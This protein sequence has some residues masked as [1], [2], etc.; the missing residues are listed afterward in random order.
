MILSKVINN[1][2]YEKITGITNRSI[3]GI[4]YDSRKVKENFLFVCIPGFS[5]DGHKFVNDAVRRGAVAVI[6][7]EKISPMPEVTIIYVRSSRESLANISNEFYDCPSEKLKL[8]GIT[9]TNGKTT[10]TYLIRSILQE[11]GEK[12][13]LIGTITY[14]LAGELFSSRNT[15]PESLDLQE[16]LNKMV[17]KKMDSCVMEVSSHSLALHRV[18]HCEFDV[19]VWTNLTLDH[20]D[21]HKTFNNYLNDK[22]KLFSALDKSSTKHIKKCA[23][24]NIDDEYS[25]YFIEATKVSIITYGF[26]ND[27]MIKP[28]NIVS[29]TDGL[30]FVINSKEFDLPVNLKLRGTHNIYNALAAASVGISLNIDKDIIKRGLENL[31]K[32]PGRF[33]MINTLSGF[34]VII[35][36][37]HTPDALK[38]L[39]NSVRELKPSRLICV[40]G[41]GGDRDKSKR[42]IM[43]NIAE[44]LADYT[45]ITS[46]NPR[47]E[48]PLAIINEIKKGFAKNNFKEIPN[49]KEAIYF[50]LNMSKE[51]DIVV[52]AG[53]GHEEYQVIK[54]K[55]I[56]FSDR[57]VVTKF[58]KLKNIWK[59]C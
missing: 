42:P 33:E 16:L 49:R 12:T 26:K 3:E 5:V 17:I 46:D 47:S 53:K 36:Y 54:D 55:V 29:G 2:K 32:V 4:A 18:E 57:E 39:L 50:G 48:E 52:I 11:N 20:L 13:G 19:G 44:N 21:F 34:S 40:F 41:C 25:R 43:G 15:T 45:I 28:I 8:I 38:R 23:V 37:A 58:L 51:R 9:G 6:A 14:D 27:A 1:L 35:D 24:I 10:T 30:N 7:E 56:P 59:E 22:L 31:S